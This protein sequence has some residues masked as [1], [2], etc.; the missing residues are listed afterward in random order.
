MKELIRGVFKCLDLDTIKS[1]N[2][3]VGKQQKKS[4]VLDFMTGRG[5]NKKKRLFDTTSSKV[6]SESFGNGRIVV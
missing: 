5:Q 3:S 2:I 4:L 1:S 6:H